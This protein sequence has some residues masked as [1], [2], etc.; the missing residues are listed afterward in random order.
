[1]IIREIN[2]MKKIHHKNIVSLIDIMTSPNNLYIIIELCNGGDLG[3]Y[4]KNKKPY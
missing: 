2:L 1:M 3:A 4:I